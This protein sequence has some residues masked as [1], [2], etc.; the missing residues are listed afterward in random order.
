MVSA[1]KLLVAHWYENRQ[2]VVLGGSFQAST[3]VPLGV[4][5]L[6]SELRSPEVD[7]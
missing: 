3:L 2:S 5:Y 6:L 7:G 4:E 1:V